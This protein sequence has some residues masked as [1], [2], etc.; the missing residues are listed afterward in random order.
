MA[1]NMENVSQPDM[2][3]TESEAN[4][5]ANK[6]YEE[7]LKMKGSD[8]KRILGQ[9]FSEKFDSRKVG[10]VKIT[11]SVCYLP[12]AAEA[13]N[14]EAAR[15][16]F[17]LERFVELPDSSRVNVI[18]IYRKVSDAL[19]KEGDGV[20]ELFLKRE[21][22]QDPDFDGDPS[23]FTDLS[24]L[25]RYLEGGYDLSFSMFLRHGGNVVEIGF[26]KR[27]VLVQTL[28]ENGTYL[29]LPDSK[30]D[31]YGKFKKF[32]EV[33]DIVTESLKGDSNPTE[34]VQVA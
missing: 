27:G 29:P 32:N 24:M 4:L 12:P 19:A 9:P 14:D 34:Q 16:G 18:E 10:R 11:D 15:A 1:T 8:L 30:D 23:A 21:N 33:S 6:A 17:A 3:G 2:Q 13:V 5:T 20:V 22:L 26:L 25:Q 31:F 7:L 28:S